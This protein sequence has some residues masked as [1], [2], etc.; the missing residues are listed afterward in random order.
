MRKRFPLTVSLD[1]NVVTDL[2]SS[3]G[4]ISRSAFVEKILVEGLKK[5]KENE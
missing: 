3:R 5:E 1:E 2:D 4:L